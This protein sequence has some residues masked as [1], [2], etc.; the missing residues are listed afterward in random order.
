MLNLS[1]TWKTVIWA[2]I[3]MT[4]WKGI[5]QNLNHKSLLTLLIHHKSQSKHTLSSTQHTE[6]Q[7][8][9]SIKS[10]HRSQM[11][12]S[13]RA[14]IWYIYSGEIAFFGGSPGIP[15]A[16]AKSVYRFADE[17]CINDRTPLPP[18]TAQQ[19]K[20]DDLKALAFK[21]IVS[22]IDQLSPSELVEEACSVS[23]SR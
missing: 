18:L 22:S 10:T 2:V 6:R 11:R 15:G 1:P 12:H 5:L 9:T 16:S 3:S 4:L 7:S 23:T 21:A 13:L 20:M 17:V 14:I 8:A 19:H